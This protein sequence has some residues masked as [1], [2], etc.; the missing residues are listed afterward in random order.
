MPQCIIPLESGW[1]AFPAP[2]GAE[3]HA[4]FMSYFTE[5]TV[6]DIRVEAKDSV[7]GKF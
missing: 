1:E 4:A 5:S 6:G 2:A 7:A 3:G